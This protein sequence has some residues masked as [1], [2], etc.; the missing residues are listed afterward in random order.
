MKKYAL[1]IDDRKVL[2]SRLME[3]TGLHS[4]YT[5]MPRCAY[6]VGSYTVEKEGTLVIE[7][8]AAPEIIRTLLDEG[9]IREE[10]AETPGTPETEATCGEAT[11]SECEESD[12]TVDGT[13]DTQPTVEPGA[14]AEESPEAQEPVDVDEPMDT[15][16]DTDADEAPAPAEQPTLQDVDE[17]TISLPMAGHTAQSIRNFL[18]LMYSRSPLL[19]KAM[20][21]NFTVSQGLLDTLEQ[22]TTRTVDEMLDEL[23]EYRL[24]AGTTGMTGIQITAEKISLAFAGPLTQEK[25]RAYTELCAAMNRMAIAQKRIQAKTVNDANEKYA[26]RIWLIRLGLNG[27]EHKTIRKLLMQ[28][29]SGHAAFRTEEDAEKFRVKEKAKRD[30]LKAAKQGA[31]GGV[32]ATE[33]TGPKRQRKPPHSPTVGQTA[34]PRRRRRERK[35]LTPYGGRRIRESFFH[36]TDINSENVQYQ[37]YFSP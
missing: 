1:N 26:L 34:H 8:S 36:C 24:G 20:G 30:A 11:E 29:L 31:H 7:D 22:A 28:N 3:L 16:N 21:T 37:V 2:V 32:S 10:G 13:E 15:V 12:E 17:L 35:L 19:N 33:E 9:I 5:F 23:K 18:N 14:T 4:R 25:V 27:D 6:I